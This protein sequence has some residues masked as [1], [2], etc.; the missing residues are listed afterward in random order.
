MGSIPS[1]RVEIEEISI[2]RLLI[3]AALH[4]SGLILG[5]SLSVCALYFW[6]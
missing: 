3:V 6:G 2:L 4:T 1:A 5:V